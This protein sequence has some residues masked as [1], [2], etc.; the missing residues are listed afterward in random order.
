MS[1]KAHKNFKSSFR[2]LD[3]VIILVFL[4]IAA[5][6]VNLFRLD[7]F[8]T[9]NLKNVEPAGIVIIKKNTVQRR[10][11]NRVL[12]DRLSNASP[13][14]LGDLIRVAEISAATLNIEDNGI[15]LD[16]NTLVRIVRAADGESLQLSLQTGNLSLAAGSG[17]GVIIDVNGKQVQAAPGA[18]ISAASGTGGRVSIQVNRGSAQF[19]DGAG[20]EI[21]AGQAVTMDANGNELRQRTVVVISPFPNARYL[22]DRPEPFAVN[23]SWNRINLDPSQALRLDIGTD[24]N[25]NQIF[26]TQNDLDN[27][28]QI[29]LDAGL[30]YWRLSLEDSILAA[31]RLTIADGSLE[32]E[33]PAP[34]SL[35]HYDDELPVINFQWKAVEE[36][37]SYIIDISDAPDFSP[38]RFRVDSTT[39]FLSQSGLNE[40]SWYWR[41]RPVFP[42][43]YQG[44]AS[45]SR[46]SSFRIE[47]ADTSISLEQLFDPPPEEEAP[48]DEAPQITIEAVVPSVNL[49][50]PADGASITGLTALRNETVFQWNTEAEITSSRFVISSNQ[51][52]LQGRSAVTRSNPG[53]TIRVDRLGAGTWYWTVEVQTADGLTISAPPR[54]LVVQAIP[55]LPPPGGM[56]PERNRVFDYDYLKSNRNINFRWNAVQ[57]ANAYIFTLYQQTPSGRRQIVQSTVNSASYNFTD[58]SRLDRG[59]FVWQVEAVN[60]RGSAIEQRGRAGESVFVLDFQ[61]PLP[62]Q[63]EDMGTLYGN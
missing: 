21:A 60:R 30:W 63:I 28:A 55:L 36:A 54:R 3:I 48:P 57:G 43:V 34:N 24:S 32:L 58:L 44:T 42:V 33:S 23:F 19:L 4:A 22:K 12:W 50:S 26:R 9:I 15:D 45:F 13:V 5:F 7:L 29:H 18:I 38:V 35:F 49:L 27:Q 62:V 52:P 53:R 6:S 20:R 47:K 8:Q 40:G 46:P 37:V 16:E 17:S 31:G 25:F 51:N 61:L 14:Y 39:A 56:S 41:V 11:S 10:H 1:G 2:F 59:S